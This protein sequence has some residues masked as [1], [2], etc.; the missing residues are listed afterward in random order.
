[1]VVLTV[2]D[3]RDDLGTTVT[4]F[5]SVS[6][7]PPMVLVGV[8]SDSYLSEVLGR[9]DRWAATVLSEKQRALAGRFAAAG[10]PSARLLL[11]SE[12]HHRGPLS[13]ALIPGDGLA[14]VECETRQRIE[15]GDHMLFVAE[16]LSADYIARRRGPLIRVNGRYLAPS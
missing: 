5:M 6:L 11:A 13:D 1:M 9:Q 10:R 16:V 14:S 12:P 15:A 3:G 7:A 8:G 4:S 2:R